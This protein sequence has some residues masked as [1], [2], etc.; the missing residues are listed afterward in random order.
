MASTRK[1]RFCGSRPE[2]PRKGGAKN[3]GRGGASTSSVPLRRP[4]GLAQVWRKAARA[5]AGRLG[6]DTTVLETYRANNM[7]LDDLTCCDAGK[8][9]C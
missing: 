7:Y 8:C 1:Q 9:L 5:I 2:N 6:A 3:G 4:F